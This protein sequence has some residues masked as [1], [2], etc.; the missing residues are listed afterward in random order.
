[1]EIAAIGRI[2]HEMEVASKRRT[3]HKPSAGKGDTMS[4]R[5]LLTTIGATALGFGLIIGGVSMAPDAFAQEATP[6]A[7]TTTETTQ[8][9]D[10]DAQRLAAYQSFVTALAGELGADETAVDA[11]IRAALTGQIDAQEAA[12]EL[13]VEQAAAQRAV[14]EVTE[15]PLPIGKFGGRHGFGDDG[16]R[17]GMDDASFEQVEGIVLPDPAVDDAGADAAAEDASL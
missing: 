1:M 8:V 12:G 3:K 13:S 16:P 17:G 14:I 7:G 15:A 5:T 9:V 11:A 6:A 4:P 10:R 2:A